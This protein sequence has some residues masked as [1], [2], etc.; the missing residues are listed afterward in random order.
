MLS[1]AGNNKNSGS[2]R[3]INRMK[4]RDNSNEDCIEL[5]TSIQESN[6]DYDICEENSGLCE[7][8]AYLFKKGK[9]ADSAKKGIQYTIKRFG[10]IY[11]MID[12]AIDKRK[13]LVDELR[14]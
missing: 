11:S 4:K 2:Q 12:R 14:N 9:Q 7:K 5:R 6:D 8:V 13:S 10:H 1:E 3:A